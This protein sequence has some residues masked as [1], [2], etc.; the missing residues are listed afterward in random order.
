[1]RQRILNNVC[2]LVILSV[3]LT[4]LAVAAVFYHSIDTNRKSSLREEAEYLQYALE[5]VG[6]SYLNENVG[7]VTDSRITLVGKDGTVLFDSA[8]D[9]D[10][11]ENHG[12]RPEFIKARKNGSCEMS[13]FSET[14]S[15]QTYYYALLLDSGKV[16][17]VSKTED[18]IF[19]TM[20]SSLTLLGI[21][22]VVV[23][24]AAILV[25]QRQIKQIIAPI[26]HL[27][28]EHPLRNVEYEELKPLLVRVDQQNKQIADQVEQLKK[29]QF[30]KEKAEMAR[31]EFSANV[32]HELKTPLM[33]ISGYAELIKNG[34][35]RS[36]DV[37]EFAGRIYK[38][39][40][41]LKTLVEDI[42]Q[43][44]KM[45][46]NN[47][48]MPFEQVDLFELTKEIVNSAQ[49]PASRKE[50]TLEFTGEPV[51]MEGVRQVLYEIFY[52]LV[53]NAIKYNLE[54]GKVSIQLKEN[55]R[56]IFWTICDTGIGIAKEEQERVFE[57]FY[58][59]DKSHSRSTGGTGLGLSIVKHGAMLHRAKV[60]VTSELGNGTEITIKFPKNRG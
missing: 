26:N 8:K 32:S 40:S 60:N 50:V 34:M 39:A 42:I 20:S 9:A 33:S 14:L 37:P 54:G 16:L 47:S 12:D 6:D 15:E 29:K 56:N 23:L 58:R 1:M 18:S 44:S 46:E 35:V 3:V 28:L 52:N 10:D 11:M 30:E 31:K 49:V 21:L 2:F 38:E 22:L 53:D 17:R 7:N 48:Q 5:Q 36:E 45:D 24:V 57:R 4:F 19:H 41:R 13:R 59:V 25:V 55:K 27:D 43:L 51:S